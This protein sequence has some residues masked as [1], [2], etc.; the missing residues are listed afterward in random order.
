MAVLQ[1]H[2]IIPLIFIVIMLALSAANLGLTV[3]VIAWVDSDSVINGETQIL[4]SNYAGGMYSFKS[5]KYAI[6]PE[7]FNKT[8]TTFMFWTGAG[9]IVDSILLGS[10]MFVK[11]DRPPMRFSLG[12]K[13]LSYFDSLT[14]IPLIL[15][16]HDNC[17]LWK[18]LFPIT[19]VPV[20]C[21]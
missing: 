18:S 10:L 11:R 15:N 8:S 2:Q 5:I 19:V 20:P 7:G 21:T 4:A 9:G 1:L 3:K 13:V 12:G 16:I 17:T 14:F 6:L